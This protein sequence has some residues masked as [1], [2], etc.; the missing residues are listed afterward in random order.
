M[1]FP[2]SVIDEAWIRQSG[3]CAKCC[4]DL[5]RMN[6]D[7]GAVGAWH[8]HHRTPVHLGGAD[9]LQNCVIFC[10]NEPENCHFNVGHSGNWNHFAPLKDSELPCLVVYDVPL[11]R[12]KPQKAPWE[13]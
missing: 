8:A 1:V 13:I 2:D 3:K 11:W 4:K 10:I 5:T 12:Q 6:R 9:T 7:Y